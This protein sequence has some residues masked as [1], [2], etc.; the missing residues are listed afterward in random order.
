MRQFR[1]IPVMVVSMLI[2]AAMAGAVAVAQ[3]DADIVHVCL[4]NE[5]MKV[6][7]DAEACADGETSLSLATEAALEAVQASNSNLEARV[8]AL[9]TFTRRAVGNTAAIVD[10]GRG[11]STTTSEIVGQVV[12]IT[13]CVTEGVDCIELRTRV[14]DG[15][16]RGAIVTFDAGTQGFDAVV[17]RL[18]NGVD[19]WLAI[20]RSAVL[21]D[22]TFGG[23]GGI[24]GN[25]SGN[26]FETAQT[27]TGVGYVDLAG[28]EIDR[29]DVHVQS[30][31][32][33]FDES[34]Q[35]WS[36]SIDYRL[37]FGI[38]DAG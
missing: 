26:F 34:E 15:D 4:K 22:G 9:E 16:D 37:F 33:F 17:D 3:H 35:R 11:T 18:T 23:G 29:I 13:S 36:S 28:L 38:A 32:V 5:K 20:E 7:D 8:S 21:A 10:I 31:S 14:L 2:G 25:E 1:F 6:V 12:L 19:E 27:S 24:I 30:I